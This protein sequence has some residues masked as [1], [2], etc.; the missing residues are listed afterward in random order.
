MQANS[1]DLNDFYESSLNRLDKCNGGNYDEGEKIYTKEIIYLREKKYKYSKI[2]SKLKDIERDVGGIIHDITNQLE[3]LK[4]ENDNNREYEL[5]VVPNI[6][7]RLIKKDASLLASN[8][9]NLTEWEH[10]ENILNINDKYFENKYDE[11][12]SG[13]GYDIIKG[14]SEFDETYKDLMKNNVLLGA[15]ALLCLLTGGFAIPLVLLL[16]PKARYSIKKLWKLRKLSKKK[17]LVVK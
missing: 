1:F 8:Y 14:D 7:K 2:L 13:D 12:V 10:R 9:E 17:L 11:I 15:V 16:L 3:T 5:A 6:E 4:K